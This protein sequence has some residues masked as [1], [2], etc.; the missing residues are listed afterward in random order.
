MSSV[1]DIC[2]LALSWLGEKPIISLDDESDAAALCKANYAPLRDAVLESAEWTFALT[3]ARL[4]PIV[5]N[6]P[7]WADFSGARFQIPGEIIRVIGVYPRVDMEL[8][9]ALKYEQEDRLIIIRTTLRAGEGAE[10][11]FIR[12]ILRVTDPVK[13]TPSFEQALAERLAWEMAIP[14]TNSPNIE[15]GKGQKYMTKVTDAT[16][17]NGLSQTSKRLRSSWLINARN[18]GA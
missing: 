18:R 1:V 9:S 15:Q 7:V 17:L 3:R 2:N 14:I 4:V 8:W 16:S 6:N 12:G 11:I 13:F 10:A 5:D